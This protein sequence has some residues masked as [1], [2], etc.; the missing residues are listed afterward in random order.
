MAQIYLHQNNPKLCSSALEQALSSNFE[1][2][3]VY[4]IVMVIFI[5]HETVY[6]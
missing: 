5:G 1:V 2:Y 6:G 4:N 3:I